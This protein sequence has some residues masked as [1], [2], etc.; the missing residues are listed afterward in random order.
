MIDSMLDTANSLASLMTE[1]TDA[2]GERGRLADHE[3][4]VAAKRRLVAQLEAEIVR[5]NREVPAWMDDLDEDQDAALSQAMAT[6]RDAAISNVAVVDRQLTL[7]N[8]LIEAVAAEARRLTG[9]AGCSYLG[10]GSMMLREGTSPISVN[11]Q[12]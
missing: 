3:E 6:L 12:L 5:L 10:S 11:T 9:N 8:D 1:E 2:L 4:L 7:S